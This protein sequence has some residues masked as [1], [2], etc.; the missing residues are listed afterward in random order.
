MKYYV[1]FET[2]LVRKNVPHGNECGVSLVR[3]LSI[4][5]GVK[6]HKLGNVK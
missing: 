2:L 6:P 4:I 3:Y 1:T 5:G